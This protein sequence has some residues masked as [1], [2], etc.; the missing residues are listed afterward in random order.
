[1]RTN[2]DKKTTILPIWRLQ[3]GCCRTNAAEAEATT[4]ERNIACLN[5]GKALGRRLRLV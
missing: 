5:R 2:G 3:L 4:G 1:V